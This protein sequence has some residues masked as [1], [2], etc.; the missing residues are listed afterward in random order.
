M[1]RTFPWGAAAAALVVT[2]ASAAFPAPGFAQ[3]QKVAWKMQSA[4]GSQLTHLGPSGQRF[5]KDVEEM[6]DG[7]FQIRFY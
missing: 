7:N 6:T 2:A 4:F 5:A 1:N 3:Q